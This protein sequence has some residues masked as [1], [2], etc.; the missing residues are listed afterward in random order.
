[1]LGPY[2]ERLSVK[3]NIPFD[4]CPS[5]PAAC[6]V[7]VYLPSPMLPLTTAI[8]DFSDMEC[9]G[10]RSTLPDGPATSILLTDTSGFSSN[11]SSTCW[12]TALKTAPSAGSVFCSFVWARGAAESVSA[13]RTIETIPTSRDVFGLILSPEW[14]CKHHGAV[15]SI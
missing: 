14:Q 1:M 2:R 10:P 12:G 15:T 3:L 6:Q 7:T 9:V 13:T 11:Q 8:R 5:S 4:T